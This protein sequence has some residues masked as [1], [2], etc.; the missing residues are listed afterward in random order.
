MSDTHSSAVASTAAVRTSGET[1]RQRA[2]RALRPRRR[3]R[4]NLPVELD[5]FDVALEDERPIRRRISGTSAA[6]SGRR[7]RT[8][9]SGS[10]SGR[11]MLSERWRSRSVFL[12]R[13]PQDPNL[14]AATVPRYPRSRNKSAGVRLVHEKCLAGEVHR[15]DAVQ[16][17]RADP[18]R[19][20]TRFGQ[21]EPAEPRSGETK[22]T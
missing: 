17:E 11:P 21:P 10:T 9:R 16:H 5:A 18:T 14:S 20:A 12:R 8:R 19:G 22:V 6:P 15:P 13:R 1:Q 2:R 7:S 4:L 3:Q